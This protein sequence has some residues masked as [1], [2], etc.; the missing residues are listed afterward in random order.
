MKCLCGL[1]LIGLVLAGCNVPSAATPTQV[2]GLAFTQVA[3]TLS[4]ELTLMAYYSTPPATDIP[5]LLATATPSPTATSTPTVIPTAPAQPPVPPVTRCDWVGFVSDVT[6][7]DGSSFPPS[8]PFTKTWRLKNI[9]TCTWTTAYK[10][11]FHQGDAMGGTAINLPANVA[12]GQTID[13]PLNLV[14]PSAPGHYRGYWMLQNASGVKFGTGAQANRAFWVDIN[15][16]GSSATTTT[17][18]ADT[19]DPSVPGQSVTVSVTVTGSGSVTPTGT[20]AIT[21]ADVNCTITLSSGSGSCNVVF[22]SAG[23]KTITATYSGDASYASSSDTESHTVNK[24]NSTTT[25]TADTPDPSAVGASVTVSVT[26]SGAGVTPTGTVAITGA[27]SNCNITLAGGSGSCNVV[28]NS[29]GVK[30]ITATYSGDSNYNGSGDTESHTVKNPSTT[31]ITGN[32]PNPSTPGQSVAIGVQVSGSGPTPTGTVTISGADVNCTITLAGG[33]GSCNVVFNTTGAKTITA[34]Y[35]GDANYA[36][37]SATQAHNVVLGPSTVTIT[38]HTPHPSVVGQSVTVSVTVS[39]AGATPT[40]TV[41]ITGADINC[42]ITLAGGSGSCNVVF[43]TTGAK[44][45][46]ATYSGDMNYSS[47]TDSVTHNVNPG[48]TIT[49]ITSDLPDPSGPGAT[50][51]ITVVVSGA[52]VTPTGTVDITFAGPGSV[53]GVGPNPCGLGIPLIGGTA[54][55]QATFTTIGSYTITAAYSGDAN[56]LTSTDT[57]PHDVY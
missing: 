36:P 11:V 22:N 33:S 12:P 29:T 23:A 18:T 44:T 5:V 21:G 35:S 50:V 13:L 17:I 1:L 27:D 53:S 40:G 2:P 42:N 48:T 39:G 38:A 31:S 55:C 47:S 56:Y 45:I 54:T 6:V 20:I 51:T 9:G 8:T 25:I 19:P 16:T 46:T 32:V 37:S 30:T 57:E 7:P 28:F 41:A 24:G 26:V 14:A 10:L 49:T 34:T 3:Q 43:N 15:V 4:A 52:G